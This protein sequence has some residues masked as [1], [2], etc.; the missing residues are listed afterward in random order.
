VNAFENQSP[1]R[2]RVLELLKR[3][4]ALAATEIARRLGFSDVAARQHLAVLDEAG[5]VVSETQAPA[6]RGRPATLWSLADKARALFPDR[7]GE[8]AVGL[9]EAIREAGGEETLLRIVEVRARDQENLYRGLMP[10]RSASLRKRVQALADQRTAEGYMAEVVQEKPGVYL[11][12]EHHCPIC[13]AAAACTGLCRA[14]LE[15]FERV[16]GDEVE[17]ERTSHL[18]SD[19]DRCVYRIRARPGS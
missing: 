1:A 9:I 4:G 18:L 14:E 6:G 19:G 17:I 13:D 7:H 10:P 15:V 12:I 8:L 2:R 5:L 3:A 11:L 16:L